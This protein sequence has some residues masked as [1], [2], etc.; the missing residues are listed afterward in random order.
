M[1]LLR[2][3]LWTAIIG[4]FLLPVS[5][6]QAQDAS[7]DP[8]TGVQAALG[9]SSAGS[10]A[11]T[12]AMDAQEVHILAGHSVIINMEA[13]MQRVLVSNPDVIHTM[14]AS[15]TQLVMMAKGPGASSVII[16]DT[17]GHSR[18]LDVRSDVDVAGLRDALQQA[19]PSESIQVAA[20]QSKVLLSGALPSKAA[21]DDVMKIAN[22]YTKDVVNSISVAQKQHGR[23]IML[24][25]KFAEVDRTKL[26]QFGFNILSTGATNT[27]GTISTQQFGPPSLGS[28][29]SAIKQAAGSLTVSDLL[30]VF[31]F[32]PDL[33]L[34]ATL[35]DL[36]QKNVLQI[37]AEPNLLA[38]NGQ[39]A[40]F[41]AGGEFPFPVVQGGTQNNNAITV[42]FRQFG[43]QLEFLAVIEDG[44]VIR[45]K[46]SPEVS[47]LDF[48]NALT[49]SGFV[50]PALSTRRAETEIELK[51]GQSFGIAGMLDRRTTV[52]LSKMP[53]IGD[54][55]ILGQLFRSKS[56]NNTA[57]ELIVIVTPTI[58]DPVAQ[59]AAAP[60][61]PARPFPLLNEKKF[62][63]SVRKKE[64]KEPAAPP[65]ARPQ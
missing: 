22:S 9:T 40:K 54:I 59:A 44:D 53:G 49:I 36:Q 13:M 21:F 6:L 25:V 39:S 55:P 58:V 50:I 63:E 33:N 35:R 48:A 20:D 45:L 5:G 31:L 37:L 27:V 26:D 34:G 30:N 52:Q 57:T 4:A 11:A 18:I 16:W 19:Y 32:R 62:D 15:P 14:T 10:P 61:A 47:A 43:V 38:M 17:A 56:I 28:S 41:L 8:Q 42:Q 24:Q 7:H 64:E 2:L 1:H 46:V 65:P 23:Q 51:N 29:S 12:G 60:P 3:I